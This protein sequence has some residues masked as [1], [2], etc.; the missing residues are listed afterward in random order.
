LI[1]LPITSPTTSPTRALHAAARPASPS[2]TLCGHR[3]RLSQ[4]ELQ[5]QTRTAA[6]CRHF[7]HTAP[8]PLHPI[9]AKFRDHTRQLPWPLGT[10]I[11]LCCDPLFAVGN[12]AP[13][14]DCEV[15]PVAALPSALYHPLHALRR[16]SAT[17]PWLNHRRPPTPKSQT[18]RMAAPSPVLCRRFRRSPAR[19]T[20]P[21]P[22]LPPL[23][24]KLRSTWPAPCRLQ[25]TVSS[26]SAVP[27]RSTRTPLPNHKRSRRA[28]TSIRGAG[29]M[30]LAGRP[31]ARLPP[32]RHS[33]HN[34]T[35]CD[36]PRARRHPSQS[37]LPAPRARLVSNC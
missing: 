17:S 7:R 36:S 20:T 30:T 33:R 6:R 5:L 8:F 35:E 34:A 25:S 9:P 3:P 29:P 14:S 18:T 13:W 21:S 32:S 4:R 10:P 22:P 2:P 19:Q 24:P 37:T 12:A 23:L 11:P 1:S 28:T 15:A 31:R 26:P 27:Y 16:L